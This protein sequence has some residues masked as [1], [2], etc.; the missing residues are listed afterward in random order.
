MENNDLQSNIIIRKNADKDLKS[1]III[2]RNNENNLSSSVNIKRLKDLKSSIN[3]PMSNK[4]FGH[5]ILKGVESDTSL[6]TLML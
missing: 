5:V 6:K 2:K 1:N 3:I 4:M